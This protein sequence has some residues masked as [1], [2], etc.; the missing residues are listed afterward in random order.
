MSLR[1]V[2]AGLG[3][4]G[5]LSLKVALEKLLGAPCYH[6]AEVFQHPEHI[7][8]WRAAARGRMPHWQSLL[9]GYAAAVDW[10]AASFWPELSQAFPDAVVLLSVRDAQSWWE[11]ASR[12][13]FLTSK[14]EVGTPWRAMIDEVFAA[15]FTTD[16]DNREAAIA[17]Y[18]AHNRQV[19]ERVPRHRLLEWQASDGWGPLCDALRLP[20]PDEPFP[21]TNTRDEFIVVHGLDAS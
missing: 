11:S 16:I 13:I 10:P 17:A 18:E 5:T 3:R 14:K 6:M 1:V 8:S 9:G 12:T 2:G 4:T 20:V 19:R 7:E 15:R 21:R